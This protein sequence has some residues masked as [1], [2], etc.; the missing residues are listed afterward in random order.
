MAITYLIAGGTANAD[1]S[2]F[3]MDATTSVQPSM[4]NEITKHP[5]EL[6]SEITDHVVNKNKS[7]SVEGV[8]TN[9]PVFVSRK[10]II[11]GQGRRTEVAYKALEELRD[12]RTPFT[13]VTE[14][15]S[16]PNCVIRSLVLPTLQTHDA[17]SVQMVV[18]QIR[19][20]STEFVLFVEPE[21]R[22]DSTDTQHNGKGQTEEFKLGSRLGEL[23]FF[24]T[25]D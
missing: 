18:E 7:F 25:P 6:G 10:N 14:F 5:V 4:D 15:R 2:F 19:V 8:V 3:E 17:L 23:L 9:A 20:V 1:L 11:E 22:D 13:L 24:D 21:K 12:K 16:Y